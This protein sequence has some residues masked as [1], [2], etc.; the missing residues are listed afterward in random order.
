MVNL[1][2]NTEKALEEKTGKTVITFK[3]VD[4]GNCVTIIIVKK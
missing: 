1:V 2:K 3:D 4:V